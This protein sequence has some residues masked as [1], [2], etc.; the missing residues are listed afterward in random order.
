MTTLSPQ[1]PDDFSGTDPMAPRACAL[2]LVGKVLERR[3]PLDSLLE[4]EELFR[5]LP[6]RDRAFVRMLVA[7][8]L[9][10]LGQIDAL[11]ARV[12][13]RPDAPRPP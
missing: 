9:R 2:D 12:Q 3:L 8:V 6:S 7:T 11:I 13:D 5:V 10:R 1:T 4:G